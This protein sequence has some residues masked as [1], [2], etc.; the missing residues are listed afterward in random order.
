MEVCESILLRMDAAKG[1]NCNAA[2]CSLYLTRMFLASAFGRGGGGVDEGRERAEGLILLST[3][4]EM[5]DLLQY[6]PM[7]IDTKKTS[8]R[9][10]ARSLLS[11]GNSPFSR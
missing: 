10:R 7:E 9:S 6:P 11:V 4:M 5:A 1:L 8:R 2:T 3:D